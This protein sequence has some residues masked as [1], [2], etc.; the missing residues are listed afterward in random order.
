MTGSWWKRLLIGLAVVVVTVLLV[1]R[2]NGNG[3][4]YQP[5]V[6]PGIAIGA[7]LALVPATGYFGRMAMFLLGG[8]IGT[9]M[10]LLR[11][12]LFPQTPTGVM[13]AW[14]VTVLILTIIWIASVGYWPLWAGLLGTVLVEAAYENRFAFKPPLV[15]SDLLPYIFPCLVAS[16]ISFV[17]VLILVMIFG[18]DRLKSEEEGEEEPSAPPPSSAEADTVAMTPAQ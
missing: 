15:T 8:A 12:G 17:V 5:I 14:A 2:F 9:L 16:A 10:F 4:F 3:Q 18:E 1:P 6:Y 7:I 11:G 13:L